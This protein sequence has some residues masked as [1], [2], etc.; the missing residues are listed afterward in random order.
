MYCFYCG[1]CCKRLSPIS[2]PEPCPYL[3]NDG[4]F[5]FCSRYTR[6]PKEC[7]NYEYQTRFCPIGIQVLGLNSTDKTRERI[8]TGW[9]KIKRLETTDKERVK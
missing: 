2:N 7:S 3:I 8:D 4:S 1:D 5:V 9:G 6:R